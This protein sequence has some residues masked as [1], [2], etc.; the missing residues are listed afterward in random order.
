MLS[1]NHAVSGAT[2]NNSIVASDHDVPQDLVYQVLDGFERN[3]CPP[4][5]AGLG[6]RAEEAL[7]GVWI[8]INEYALS[9]SSMKH[10][11]PG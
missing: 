2:V 1:Y 3:Y 5:I 6:W 7:F 8:G 9:L 11:C 10:R 4:H